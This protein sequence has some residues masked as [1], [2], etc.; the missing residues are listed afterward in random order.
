[1]PELTISESTHRTGLRKFRRYKYLY[2]MLL[3]SVVYYLIFHYGPMYGAVIAF[4]QFSPFSGIFGSP[5]VGFQHFKD[6]Y[7][8]YYFWR[9]IRNTLSINL[10]DVIFGFPAPIIL[11]LLLNEVRNQVFKRT[12]QTITYMPHFVSLVV[13]VGLIIDFCSSRGLLNMIVTFFGA[14]PIPF[15]TTPGLFQPLYVAS[16]IWQHIGWG[17]IIYLA[18]LSGIDP[19]LYEQA[20]VDGAGRFRKLLHITLPG[21]APTIVILLILRCGR[22]MTVGFEKIMLMYNPSVYETADV[23]STFVYRKG[24]LDMSFS[25][26]AAVGLFNSAISFTLLVIVNWISRRLNETSLW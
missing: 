20:E 2:L 17:T 18:A 8:S 13:V 3:P 21:L 16:G 22:M 19:Q 26:A 1:M 9:L 6:F 14:R 25:Y 7:H 15:M 10:L 4:K 11:A 5:W 23:I 12:V 24:L